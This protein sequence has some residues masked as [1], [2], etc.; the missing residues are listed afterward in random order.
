MIE[1]ER[2]EAGR[3]NH[4]EDIAIV[5]MSCLFPRAD[6]PRQ[7]WENIVRC[8]DAV[9]DPP[10]DWPV[11]LFAEALGDS[12][13]ARQVGRGGYLG[14]LCRFDPIRY[15][16]MPNSIDG[17]EPD[18]FIALRCAIEALADAG[19]PE[20]GLNH[21]KTGV[22]LGR[23]TW[24]N[25]AYATLLDHSLLVDQVV[26]V[27]HQLEPD[28]SRD[29]LALIRAE[30]RRNLPP[31]SA[32][33]APGQVP[34]VMVGRIANRLNLNGPAYAVDGACASALLAVEHAVHDLRSG[35]CDAVL[36]GGVQV[37]TP[38]LIHF[39]FSHVDALSRTGR[40]APFSAEAN[41]T[42]LGQGC[43][44]LVLK[45]RTDAERQGHRI[46]ALIKG[47]GSSSDGAGVG[48]LAPRQQGQELAL[49]RAYEETGI[50][51]RSIGLI[52]AHGTGT[53]LGDLTEVRTLTSCFG[54]RGPDGA[55]VAMGSVK[56]MISHLIPA[57]GAAALI[58][59]ALAL[60]HRVLPPTLYADKP[61]AELELDKT[62]FYLNGQTR[63][64]IHGRQGV[65]R[66]AGVNAFG[67]GGINAHAIL[68]EHVPSDETSLE[69]LER[70]WPVEL[71]V[72]S[73]T[74]RQALAARCQH[75]AQWV[76]AAEGAEL[77]DIAA[78]LAAEWNDQTATDAPRTCVAI[79]ARDS[80]D[81][82]RKLRHVAERLEDAQRERIQDR[83]G[84]FWYAQ[85]LGHQGKLAFVFPGE[86]AQYVD[87]LSDLARHF[88]EVRRQFDLTDL[89]FARA[90]A[91]RLP[92]RNIFPIPEERELA[93]RELFE[94]TGAVEAVTTANRALAALLERLGVRPDAVMGHSSGEYAALVTAGVTPIDDDEAL[95][96][97][98]AEGCHTQEE[99]LLSDLVPQAVLTIVGGVDRS[100]VQDCIQQAGAHVEIA[101]D[102]CPNQVVLCTDAD[103]TQQLLKL[104]RSRGALCQVLPWNRA[105]HTAA[106][107]PACEPLKRYFEKLPFAPP[108]VEIWS[109]ATASPYPSNVDAARE[110]A[111]RQWKS[112]VRFRETI[113]AMYDAGVR[114][115][116][117]VGPRGNL[118]TFIADTLADRP[119]AAVPVNVARK[120]GVE[121]LCRALG[122]LAAHGV[123]LRLDELYR[124]RCPAT[125]DLA[126]DPPAK[127][128]PQPRLP[129]DLPRLYLRDEIV[130][131]L[132]R[133][134]TAASNDNNTAET[135]AQH[136]ATDERASAPT[137]AS[138]DEP[139]GSGGTT[140]STAAGGTARRASPAV[141][142]SGSL[143]PGSPP[144]TSPTSPSV[145]RTILSG[146]VL[147]SGPRSPA[148]RDRR[149]TGAVRLPAASSPT[150]SNDPRLRAFGELQK[151][152]QRFLASQ[153]FALDCRTGCS[154]NMTAPANG[155]PWP[156]LANDV[157]ARDNGTNGRSEES[158]HMSS[159]NHVADATAYA[160]D[161]TA[162]NASARADVLPPPATVHYRPF[163][164]RI[165]VHEA[166]RRLVA[167]CDLNT[168]DYGF[169]RD[170]CFGRRVSLR[171]PSLRGL[172]LM[173]AALMTEMMAEAAAALFPQK[174]VSALRDLTF[175]RWVIFDRPER[176][177]EV[178]ATRIDQSNVNVS[179]READVAGS[180]P[181]ATGTVELA[182]E[183]PKDLG[184]RRLE[185]T[186][187]R[188]S[189][190]TAETVYGLGGF[191]GPALRVVRSMDGY[192]DDSARSTLEEPDPSLMF[193]RDPSARLILPAA[194]MDGV[195]LA[196]GL[197]YAEWE[198]KPSFPTNVQR[199]EFVA[200]RP[201]GPLPTVIR[202]VAQEGPTTVCDSETCT[203]Q[204]QVV[205]RIVGA[206]DVTI[207]LEGAFWRFRAEP[208]KRF[209]TRDAT[210]A[211]AHVPGI[212]HATLCEL[213][214][215][216]SPVLLQNSG[217]WSLALSRL[218]LSRREREIYDQLKRP[219]L[220]RASWLL[221]R[222]VVKD[223]VRCRL[224]DACCM[225]D[226]E[227]L[228]D[229]HGRPLID[230]GGA[231]APLVSLAHREY[232]AIGVAVDAHAAA[233]VGIDL[234]PV[235]PLE[236]SVLADTYD[237]QER[238]LL[239][240]AAAASPDD[241]S[242][243]QLAGWCSKEAAGKALGRGVLGGPR[244]IRLVEI[245]ASMRRF[246]VVL[247]GPMAEAFPAY[248]GGADRAPSSIHIYWQRLGNAVV[249]LCLL[250]ARS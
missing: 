44:I 66:R 63:P 90:G 190:W 95:L 106:F 82:V 224:A 223:A 104:L 153:Q 98:V 174:H 159:A 228:N 133:Q 124:R 42:L 5:G 217:F 4:L 78:A 35:R 189:R 237:A 14:D 45:R 196:R 236:P 102:N 187:N 144:S 119:H 17:S 59:T 69:R 171:D 108:K 199:L 34:T 117:E 128:R 58:K 121:Q 234:E 103:T 47:V 100:V 10:P 235:H 6:G 57:S 248:A 20:I 125:I 238:S 244:S 184:P 50:D 123:S 226:V 188:T 113:L 54:Q 127:P 201:A 93:E 208:H 92:S 134:A 27:L 29:E 230:L 155:D 172:P 156:A 114:L 215:F 219:P 18:Q 241:L 40:I 31:A 135:I 207:D 165:V 185:A 154:G 229:T 51:T 249:S 120:S 160:S 242:L 195:G 30:L 64:W 138:V 112:Q 79:V 233:G 191:Q 37:S 94:M 183:P 140:D 225:A 206:R 26:E 186:G 178:E 210:K 13:A 164:Q 175:T 28:R 12:E 197:W 148:L 194:L 65:P 110:L 214:G 167:Q 88:P 43:G 136:T 99:M 19:Y 111:V 213:D 209:F 158:L 2:E 131:Q 73:A 145:D 139:S 107:E 55:N 74:D 24:F 101:V 211:F 21:E 109:C 146:A 204:G 227:V 182:D 173:P 205:L 83:S 142:P 247:S 198:F 7:Y 149:A 81:L 169:I 152:M 118:T 192:D 231:P 245:D 75:L 61:R 180:E 115:F 129:L 60:Y 52:E 130:A 240:T 80:H 161:T 143:P 48:L 126:G 87:M 53:P 22:I 32:E 39:V 222:I 176:C 147:P 150:C 212:E 243:W 71:V 33:T 41:G 96:H 216:G 137:S 15:R 3:Q 232:D 200:H 9:G 105:Y 91:A 49:R 84:I 76:E 70:H 46:Y 177:L 68:E 62:P 239:E 1:R 203:P 202:K 132:A 11:H 89:A 38:A 166:S 86:G 97:A 25:R 77:L 181:V 170:H 220:A 250:P 116:L 193:P 36:V 23:G 151:T 67:F 85:P 157:Q 56:S 72:V 221:G 218:I 141:S 8:V 162:G 246:S 179:I 168:E 163:L 122:M 16:V